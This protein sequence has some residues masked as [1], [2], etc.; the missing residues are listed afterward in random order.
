MFTLKLIKFE[1]EERTS[2]GQFYFPSTTSVMRKPLGWVKG[3]HWRTNLQLGIEESPLTREHPQIDRARRLLQKQGCA[4]T[5]I[6]A[7]AGDLTYI[8]FQG[9]PPEIKRRKKTR[10]H[11]HPHDGLPHNP[12]GH[13]VGCTCWGCG[14]WRPRA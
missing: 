5:E 4:Y 9:T 2:G 13:I 11:T 8:I 7:G 6:E 12:N 3:G 14:N 1:T 10:K